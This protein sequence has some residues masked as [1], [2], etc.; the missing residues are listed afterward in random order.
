VYCIRIL[1]ELITLLVPHLT[2]GLQFGTTS[3]KSNIFDTTTCIPKTFLV[4]TNS[5]LPRGA[6]WSQSSTFIFMTK[7]SLHTACHDPTGLDAPRIM[8]P[9]VWMHRFLHK[10]LRPH[11]PTCSASEIHRWRRRRKMAGSHEEGS[12]ES[13][14]RSSPAT[15]R[16][17][18]LREGRTSP[19]TR[20]GG[21]A[22]S[23]V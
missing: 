8:T 20:W 19:A 22:S 11:A 15:R 14:E 6:A 17:A 10:P 7:T 21:A 16:G 4:L 1:L 9:P 23:G 5:K 2:L 13:T 18:R 3:C 12:L